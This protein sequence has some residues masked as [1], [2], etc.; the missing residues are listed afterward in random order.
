VAHPK[1]ATVVGRSLMTATAAA[2]MVGPLAAAGAAQTLDGV[3]DAVEMTCKE[4]FATDDATLRETLTDKFCTQAELD[5]LTSPLDKSVDEVTE[6]VDETVTKV[7]PTSAPVPPEGETGGETG[8]GG[9]GS[10][11]PLPGDGSGGG[12]PTG[13][14][15]DVENTG[16]GFQSVDEG[17]QSR[18]RN[19]N[20]ASAGTTTTPESHGYGY[21]ADGPFRPGMQ[22]HS[23]LTL[24]PFAAPLVSVPPIYE[25]PQIASQ[26]FGSDAA[27]GAEAPVTATQ[28]SPYS[29]AGYSAT[30]ADPTGWLAA[31]ATGL[32]MLVG[33]GHAINGG[34]TP[35]HHRA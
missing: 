3:T 19:R 16:G 6:T 23:A 22:S 2:L 30:S 32:I 33:A 9:G 31:T 26:L 20:R 11:T 28:A 4:A 21:N 35:K 14:G 24:Q 15:T 17:N 34:R 10:G 5:A 8:G 25:L 1:L 18:T 12:D 29:P 27:V 13:S 7:A